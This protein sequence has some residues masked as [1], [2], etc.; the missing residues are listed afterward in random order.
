MSEE[1]KKK[2]KK[3]DTKKEEEIVKLSSEVDH[4][5]NEFYKAYADTQ[6]LRK[7]LE[8]DHKTAMKYR[9]EGFIDNL[10]PVLDSFHMALTGIIACR[11]RIIRMSVIKH[12]TAHYNVIQCIRRADRY[13][14]RQERR[15]RK[16][17][18]G[19]CLADGA[20]AKAVR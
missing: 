11:C 9:A 1:I 8:K 6:N 15:G 5:K 4:W 12:A 10:L 14:Q 19:L 2:E 17:Q 3:K 18:H 13:H 16:R 20:S 7:S